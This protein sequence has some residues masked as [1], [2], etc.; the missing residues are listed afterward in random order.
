MCG[1]ACSFSS[2]TQLH[3]PTKIHLPD[4]SISYATHL[5]T[6][7]LSPTLTL[8]DVLLIPSFKHNLLSVSQLCKSLSVAF[9]FLTSSCVLQEL[10]TKHPLAIGKQVG[11][12]YLLDSSSFVSVASLQQSCCSAECAFANSSKY[13]VWHKRL[14]HSIPLVLAHIH[15]LNIPTPS[16]DAGPTF[17]PTY[18]LDPPAD[19][20]SDNISPYESDSVPS[21]THSLPLQTSEPIVPPRRSTRHT[22]HLLG[23]MTSIE[24]SS[25]LQ[26]QGCKEWE[27]AISQ[28]LSA[29]E[30]NNT[31]EVVD[32][33]RGKKAIGCK[34]V[35]KIKL[36]A[37]G[38]IDRY[39]ARILLVV[40]SSHG[41]HIHQVDI[42][43]AFLH[44]FLDEDIYM[45]APDGYHIQP[46]KVCKLKRS[47]YGLKQASRQWN[48]ELTN[49]LISHGFHQSS[50]DHC[51]FTQHTEAGLIALIVYVDDVLITCPSEVKIAEIKAFLD[52][53]FTIKD[54]GYAKYFLGLEIAPKPASSPLPAGL[55]LSSHS[56]VPLSDPEPYRRLV[57]RLLYLSFTRPDI[58]FG[59]QQLSQFVHA[60]CAIHMEAARHLVWS[61]GKL[62]NVAR[63]TAEA[64]YRSLG[65]IVCELQWITY[66]LSDLNI[67]VPTP[68]PLYCDNQA[69]IHIVSNPVFH[70][71]T[72][73]LE[74]DC[75]LVRD[76][77]KA[78]FVLPRHI[79]GTQQLVDVLTKSLF[80]SQFTNLLSKMGLMS[81]PQ[82][83]L[84][85]GG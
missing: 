6:I 64:E 28:E 20:I 56:S 71:R 84:G 59:A 1:D 16:H 19:T 78:G 5:G 49:K 61:L 32:L 27:D 40:A 24:P 80:G 13:D 55:K 74:I 44:R 70:E 12:L 25:Y 29:L 38:S 14:G 18:I 33:P 63:S 73:H 10:M 72:E 17:V 65:T 3:T 57:G 62:R 31:W 30:K 43:N 15:E 34:W 23:S 46:G 35:Y 9:V 21:D 36:K 54:L 26:A 47:L 85:G 50:H 51:L 66:L 39:T 60:P 83:H 8:T 82:V 22:N 11:K 7:I 79:S 4:N 37:D 45:R 77:F 68:I 76:K 75:H 42:N 2:L 53:T 67:Q 81:L 52:S 69:A 48:L 41:W 58:S